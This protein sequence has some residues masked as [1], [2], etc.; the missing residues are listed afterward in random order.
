MR[1]SI[2]DRI[3]IASNRL[4]RPDR[5]GRIV[6]L[7]HPDGTPPYVVEWDDGHRGTFY[8]G[9]DAHVAHPAE[10][11]APGGEPEAF[12]VSAAPVP[13]HVKTWTVEIHV[14]ENEDFTSAHAVLHAEVPGPL[15]GEGTA[16]RKPEDV[17]V[18]EIGDEV[19]VARALRRL[20]DQLLSTAATDLADVAGHP[21]TLV[22]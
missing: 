8:P 4:D 15:E 13:K 6:E 5:H 14:F 9:A 19:A 3:V 11:A 21:V 1:A 20:A 22:R 18:P 2:G 17:P 10:Q 12:P 16:L 7:R